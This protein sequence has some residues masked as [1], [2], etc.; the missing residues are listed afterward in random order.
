MPHLS[1]N[2]PSCI[3]Y[4]AVFSEFLRIGR[5]TLRF[6]DFVPRASV[7]FKRMLSQ[8]GS[9]KLLAKQINK[10]LTRYPDVFLKFNTSSET[11]TTTIIDN[12]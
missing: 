6:E 4:G 10:V 1:S 7:L 8:G 9:K 5:C 3:F 12:A 11:L 2:I